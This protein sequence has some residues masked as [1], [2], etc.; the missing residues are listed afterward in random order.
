VRINCDMRDAYEAQQCLR[1]WLEEVDAGQ[2]DADETLHRL[3][4]IIE[5]LETTKSNVQRALGR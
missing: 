5:S 4:G 2:M 1:G 3:N